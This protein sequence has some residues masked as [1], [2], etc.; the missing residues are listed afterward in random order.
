[1]NSTF[2]CVNLPIYMGRTHQS[3]C[4]NRPSQMRS[5]VKFVFNKLHSIRTLSLFPRFSHLNT[6]RK[7]IVFYDCSSA[8]LIP[9]IWKN[10]IPFPR[11]LR[12]KNQLY[13]HLKTPQKHIWIYTQHLRWWMAIYDLAII[14]FIQSQRD[15]ICVCFRSIGHIM[16]V[17]AH[18][19]HNN[20][21]SQ[22]EIVET[23]LSTHTDRGVFAGWWY[24]SQTIGWILMKINEQRRQHAVYWGSFTDFTG[25]KGLD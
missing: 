7:C 6:N 10:G 9:D 4:D 21:R 23:Y 16:S 5:S 18:N 2:K 19:T 13:K 17:G 24:E 15:V 1:M 3:Q 12:N 22:F 20:N 11:Y 8:G 25:E 14:H